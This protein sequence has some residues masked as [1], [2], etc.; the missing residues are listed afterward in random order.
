VPELARA[1][2]TRRP[3]PLRRACVHPRT[4]TGTARDQRP[5][6]AE[7]PARRAPPA[8]TERVR[9]AGGHTLRDAAPGRRPRRIA[10]AALPFLRLRAERRPGPARER[11]RC[12]IRRPHGRPSK[13]TPGAR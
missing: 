2:L 11:D 6:G 5:R 4:S 10:D 13:S 1:C 8:R 9:R 12:S 7:C 3:R